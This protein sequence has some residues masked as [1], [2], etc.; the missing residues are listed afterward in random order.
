M[1]TERSV[2][3][4]HRSQLAIFASLL[5]VYALL[6]F[7]T[8]AFF[9]LEQLGVTTAPPPSMDMPG[10]L[11][12]LASAGGVLVLY[13]AG[14]LAGYWF[15][16]K[17]GLPGIYRERAGWRSYGLYPLM[18]GALVG[19]GIVVVDQLFTVATQREAFPHPAFPL[20]IIA[21]ATAGIGEEILFRGFVLGL[22]A[23]LFYLIL[24]R[25]QAIGA[26]LW[27]GNVIAALAFAAAHLPVVI[28]LYGVEIPAPI[29]AELFLLNGLVGLVAGERYMRDGLVAAI[30]V[31]FWADIVWH[32]IW[33]LAKSALLP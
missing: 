13:G 20:S 26:A 25:W 15:A 3:P 10:W 29:L 8:Y 6:V 5:G 19:L 17:L 14:G 16:L 2:S 12:G 30:G 24:R 28:Y 18:I 22:W 4:H 11:L 31:H 7:V 32:V 23:F 9:S 1:N 27:I 21:S 33:P